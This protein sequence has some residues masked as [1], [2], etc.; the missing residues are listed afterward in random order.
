MEKAKINAWQLF[1]LALL[2][3]FGTSIVV[4]FGLDAKK[5]AWIASLLG[6][7]LGLILF[8]VYLYLYRQFPKIPLTEYIRKIVGKYLGWPLGLLYV[9]Y[10][11]YSSARDLRDA[12][13]LLIASVYDQTPL[14]AL[15]TL[16]MVAVFYVLHKGIEVLA[17]TSE[18]CLLILV[19][20]GLLGNFAVLVSGII[21]FKN[22]LPVLENGWKPIITT[23]LTQTFIFPYGEMIAFTMILPYL[24]KPQKASKSGLSAIA[25]SGVVISY[26]T[27][28]NVSVLGVNIASRSTFPLHTMIS[29]VNIIEFIQRLDAIVVLTLI[30]ADFFKIAIFLYAAI[31]GTMDLFKIKK[32]GALVFPIGIITLFAS[33]MMA[34]NYQEHITEG[35]S[36]LKTVHL[37]FSLVVP[38]F[39]LTVLMIRKRFGS[40]QA[41][42]VSHDK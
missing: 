13:D 30:I 14:F 37:F 26:T 22:L 24:D 29:K 23:V 2:F 15:A 8:P 7:G 21:D 40:P 28:L 38:L 3:E 17:R 1:S 18:I 27:L 6:L 20:L 32:H 34:S 36:S 12:G 42:A 31:L 19:A 16:M 9:V 4:S 25:I 11:I 39:L 33:M 5:D 10:F 35:R 41:K